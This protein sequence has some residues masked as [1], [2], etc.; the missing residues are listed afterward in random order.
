LTQ[1][2]SADERERAA[3][4]RMPAVRGQFVA[5]RA[6]LRALLGAYLGVEPGRIAF[7]QGPQGKPL[8]AGPTPTSPLHFN[9]SHSD[10]IA[11][12]AVTWVG[13]VGV[14]VERLRPQPNHLEMAQRFFAP[15]ESAALRGLPAGQAE[16][17][18]FRVWTRKEAFLK[19]TG[20]GL[21]HGLERSEMSVRPG[22]PARLLRL[23]G[24][25]GLAARWSLHELEPASGYVGALAIEAQGCGL[26]CRTWIGGER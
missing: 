25:P 20:F 11:L 16:E 12:V 15:S 13:E 5:S 8:L 4:Y 18:F 2:L 22:E 3:R 1:G 6:F 9:L 10:R 19:A 21:S 14:D 7:G 17:A 24:D 23:D 26:S